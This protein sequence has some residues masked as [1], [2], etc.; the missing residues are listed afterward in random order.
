VPTEKNDGKTLGVTTKK[1]DHKVLGLSTDKN[2][3]KYLGIIPAHKKKTVP[4]PDVKA[5]VSKGN[6]EIDVDTKPSSDA[7]APT[8]PD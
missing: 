8:N 2:D 7:P 3:G 4:Q 5:D 1:N 6:V